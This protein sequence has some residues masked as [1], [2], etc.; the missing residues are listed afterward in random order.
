MPP[1]S[2]D[3][4]PLSDV[5]RQV[6]ECY[7]VVHP[8]RPSRSKAMQ[9]INRARKA[10][11]G[12]KGLVSAE[13]GAAVEELVAAGV[14]APS[15][16]AERGV[17]ARGPGALLGTITRFCE[18]ALERG[19]ADALL[20]GLES[21]DYH[22]RW[23][24][25]PALPERLEQ[26]VRLALLKGDFARFAD[27]PLPEHIWV[28]LVEPRA[29]P[30]IARLPQP[31]RREACALGLG[32][33]TEFLQPIDTF[34]GTCDELA[35][36]AGHKLLVARA[37]VFQ[38]RFA[39]ARAMI[40]AA[41]DRDD[42]DGPAAVE[43][44][45]LRATLCMIE[46]DDE[47]AFA[48][49]RT[50]LEIERA[51]TRKRIVYPAAPSLAIALPAL[52]R[53]A[54]PESL[55]LFDALTVARRKRKISTELD[56]WL[57]AAGAAAQP[58]PGALAL[59]FRGMPSAS[60]A[61]LAIASRWHRHFN[62]RT[63][64][65]HALQ[66][67]GSLIASAEHAGYAWL[68]A[69]LQHVLEST[70]SSPE[71]LPRGATGLFA[72]RTAADRHAA[73]GS[74]SLVPLVRPIEP[75][76]HALRQLEQLAPAPRA[77][78]PAAATEKAT[79]SKRLVW[80]VEDAPYE[81]SVAVTPL[82]QTRQK[83]GDW[84][85]GRRVAL[86]R[87]LEQADGL[88]YLSDQDR[89][90]GQTVR[91]IAP[92]GWGGGSPSYQ[93]DERTLHRLAGH[94]LVVDELGNPVDV[95][96][97]A[98]EIHVERGD[99]RARLEIR[100][101]WS[102]RHYQCDLD[103]SLGRLEVTHFTAAHRRIAEALPPKGLVV[104]QAA[105]SRLDAL[106]GALSADIA[107]HGHGDAPG[108]GAH[109]ADAARPG[110]PSPL[111]V[112][113]PSGEG[114]RVRIR[115]EPLAGSGSFFDAGTGGATVYVRTPEGSVALRRD[116]AVEHERMQAL[117]DGLEPLS[118]RYD[119]RP[120]F[121]LDGALDALELLDAAQEQEIRCV[122]PGNVP[123]RIRKRVDARSVALT[124]TSAKEWFA[125]DGQLD[126]GDD[127][128]I[129]LARLLQL[130]DE[131][132]ESR[133][134]EIGA[135][136]FIALSRT[137][138]Q[139]LDTLQA[140]SQ[141]PSKEGGS[142]RVHPMALLA[143]DE[144]VER[145]TLK[146]DAG[147]KKLRKRIATAFETEP[148]VPVALQAELRGYQRDGYAWLA[149]LA[150]IGAGACLAD[151]MGLGKTVQTLALLLSR[152]DAGP[153]L[154]VAPT[155][156]IGNWAAEAQRFAPSLTVVPYGAPGEDRARQLRDA[157]PFD[158][159]I[160]SYGLLVNDVEALTGV[161]WHTAVLD[162]A[163]AIKN[164]ATRRAKSARALVADARVI[165]TGTPVQ[166]DLMDLHSLFAFL[167][168]RL[169]GSEAAF[170]RR[171]GQP[172]SRDGDAH[173]REQL[174]RLVR[175][176]LLRRHKRDVLTELPAR[177][178]LTLEVELSAEEAALYEAM[179]M[180]A[181]AAL[182][183]SDAGSTGDADRDDPHGDSGDGPK[184]FEVLSHLTRLR[185]LCCHP[186]LVS[187]G[188]TGP[189]SKLALFVDTLDELIAGGH[190]A[191]VFSQFVDNL[192]L[193]EAELQ[194]RSIGYQYIDGSVSSAQR[195][196]RV[197]AFQAG[198]GQAFLISLTAGGTGLNL[199]AA[200]YV[201]HLDPWWNPAVEDQASDR[202]HRLGQQR[203]VTIVRMV[204]RGT[205]EQRIQALHATKRD[206][207][208]S[209]LAGSGGGALDLETMLSLLGSGG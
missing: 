104:P 140:F 34:A 160:A 7:A 66:Y 14:L 178:E 36:G 92:S 136:E 89:K 20:A 120:L 187:P 108:D 61:L 163:Q 45:A 31:H 49:I 154:V 157:G 53:L 129:S 32:W 197:V 97:V 64:D 114:L 131:R 41:A 205:I 124:I 103:A 43:S 165:T 169:L 111:L 167:N 98:P 42:F 142:R 128:T 201:I 138:K 16:T 106:L 4:A 39:D 183:T 185:R 166:N 191:L 116:L 147:W 28:W 87:L 182:E 44:E 26:H 153:Q 168:P 76:E 60:G 72:G 199:T 82:E 112:L 175:P 177:T 10:T 125:A 3:P 145:A 1:A 158:V 95:V 141:P 127:D 195:T 80:Q 198:E 102:G 59:E 174:H 90:V 56:H 144:L 156:V 196:A 71:R 58:H 101:P 62:F 23:G 149:R 146:S 172:V 33:L 115:V 150:G 46:G 47:A 55:A 38:G 13:M 70:V 24:R 176:F 200:D 65:A 93:T 204:T 173:A 206:L 99:G 2:T 209:V 96:E 139:Q 148:V 113:D 118:D 83:N 170:R 17:G 161:H 162:E 208:D 5:A 194:A 63:D 186:V 18:A 69:E 137:L 180:D 126:V 54:T 68:V 25:P 73:L 9:W 79:R 190:K 75:W 192:K 48:A 8:E 202:A 84:T 203:P 57:L 74:A 21:E 40:A 109:A 188:W 179:R 77:A 184:K 107:V 27:V 50:C 132:P 123:F 11:T 37:R 51:G 22:P 133:F 6:A 121:A 155:S 122:W 130:M 171:F 117:V 81:R 207:A 135:G 105:S 110:D 134:V 12:A 151:D 78:G 30:C 29:K 94:P 91:R 164:A 19:T 88:D 100:P 189:T 86:K 15:V 159:V 143:L 193:V 152:A 119:G 67:L 181:L 35:A 52:V 85:Q